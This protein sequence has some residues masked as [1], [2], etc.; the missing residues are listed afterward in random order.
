[1]I[2]ELIYIF[3]IGLG[4]SSCQSGREFVDESTY[5]TWYATHHAELKQTKS[6]EDI[7]VS[8]SLVPSESIY[9]RNK[10]SETTIADYKGMV[11]FTL[12]LSN[13]SSVPMLKYKLEDE[14]AY[15]ARVYYYT[16]EIKKHITL[17]QEGK[18]AVYATDVIMDRNYGISPHLTLNVLFKEVELNGSITLHYD[19]EV[20]NLG[21][22]NFYYSQDE[23][24]RIPTLEEPT[25]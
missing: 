8:V 2:R 1:M 6:L 15:Q 12:Q 5:E 14:Q 20:Y 21:P 25:V 13:H 9:I 17:R 4:I 7:D 24:N 22:L 19:E 18:E 3:I 10:D 11:S 23:L 16:N